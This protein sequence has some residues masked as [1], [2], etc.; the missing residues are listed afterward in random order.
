[1][2]EFTTAT[3]FLFVWV[4][5]ANLNKY[6]AAHMIPAA[7]SP[8]GGEL[9]YACSAPAR[10]MGNIFCRLCRS[11]AC[12]LCELSVLTKELGWGKKYHY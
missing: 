9:E 3:S 11:C 2:T 6:P 10:V 1:M 7:G 8:G 12:S 4:L 5:V